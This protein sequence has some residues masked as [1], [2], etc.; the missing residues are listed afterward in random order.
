MPGEEF[1]TAFRTHHGYWEFK[2]MPFG[3]TNAPATFQA[4][5]NTIFADLIRKCVLVFVNDILVYSKT[6]EEH[7]I[8]LQ[9]V[10]DI[11]QNH[12]L[13][14][15]QSKCSFAQQKLEYLGHIISPAGGSN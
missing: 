9:Q 10:F 11:S 5:M 6:L 14:V 13:Y 2:V 3:L 15:K 8:H 7:C 12:R 1:K 4:T